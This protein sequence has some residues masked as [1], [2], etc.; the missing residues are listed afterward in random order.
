[1]WIY[2][3]A[4]FGPGHQSNDYDFK[5]FHDSYG[6]EDIKD[7]LFHMLSHH[8]DIVLNFWEVDYPDGEYIQAKIENTKDK[9]KYYQKHLKMLE[10]VGRFVPDEKEG[11]DEVLIRNING[12]I[13]PD[14]LKRLHK[15]GFMYGADDISEWRYGKKKLYGET[16]SKILRIMR[17]TKKYSSI[18][19]SQ[20]KM[21]TKHV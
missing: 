2:Y 16:R 9:I 14:L 1:M 15:A 3:Y 12:C 13:I 10:K 8:Y 21:N 19:N 20:K 4:S 5:Y 6:M 18:K 7:S 11:E 17:S